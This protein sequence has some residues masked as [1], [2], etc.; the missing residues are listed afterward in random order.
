MRL[1]H[2]QRAFGGFRAAVGEK[3]PGQTAGFGNALRQRSLIFVVE[4]IRCVDQARRLFPYD[5]DNARMILSQRIHTDP[6]NEVEITLSAG[7]PHIWP[8]AACNHDRMAG[9]ILEQILRFE[10][11]NI[12]GFGH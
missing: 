2:L 8:I 5:R 7:I 10:L 11:D 9:I 4:Q 12:D 6:G 3:G 1:H